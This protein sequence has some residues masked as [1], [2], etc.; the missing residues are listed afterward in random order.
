[1]GSKTLIGS[2]KE[3]VTW[4]V[5]DRT[6]LADEILSVYVSPGKQRVM[7][8]RLEQEGAQKEKKEKL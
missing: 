6:I 8:R 5:R 4:P 2:L 7:E 3:T 1:M